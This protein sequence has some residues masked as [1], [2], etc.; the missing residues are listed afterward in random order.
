MR[1]ISPIKQPAT[2]SIT[3]KLLKLTEDFIIIFEFEGK[4]H[5]LT[6]KKNFIFNGASI[7]WFVWSLLRLAP[8]GVM[9]GPS[10]PHDCGYENQGKFEEGTLHYWLG[11]INATTWAFENYSNA[12]FW[13]VDT[14]PLTK[15]TLDLLLKHLCLWWGI[16]S[17]RSNLVYSAVRTFGWFPWRRNSR[18][19]KAQ[20]MTEEPGNVH[21]LKEL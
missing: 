15:K 5:R 6:I 21:L 7:P 4:V 9:D 17:I 12:F 3:T 10:C 16:D 18:K 19:M 8:H 14:E 13:A 1:I 2:R 11:P 20:Q